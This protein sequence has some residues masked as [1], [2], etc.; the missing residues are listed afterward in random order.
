MGGSY[1]LQAVEFLVKTFFGL[2][3]AVVM[4]RFLLQQVRA[5][6]HNP[7]SQ[8]V[9]SAT[10]PLL[11]PMRR[12]IPSIGRVDTSCLVL[13]LALQVLEMVILYGLRGYFPAPVG[14]LVSSGAELLNLAINF[15]MVLLLILVV[16]SWVGGGGYSAL[17]GVVSQLCGPLL[18][19][20]RRAIPPMG[21]F[22]L[23]VFAAFILLQ[24][25]KILLV[26]PLMDLGRRL[27]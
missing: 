8:F 14:L 7:V 26:A 27:L 10:Q 25:G 13:M 2:Y 22:D 5:D 6:F 19:P 24:L 21:M 20:L 23:S 18:R 9:V 3:I 11:R 17:L 15:Y 12:V 1:G 4:A 16:S